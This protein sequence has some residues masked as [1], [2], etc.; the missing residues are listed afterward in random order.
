MKKNRTILC[1]AALVVCA[2]AQAAAGR[3]GAVEEVVRV[4]A[5]LVQ[6]GVS[7]F[8]KQGRFVDGLKKEDFELKVDGR[9]V[10]ITFFENIV[11]G[12]SRDRL[13]RAAATG[14]PTAAKAVASA[15]SFRQRT[16]VFF[17][18]DRHLSLDS[19]GRTRKMLLD[20]IEKEMGENDLVAFASASGRIGF[21][22]Q[23]TDDKAVLR[24]AV[25]RIDHVPYV[26]T[27][28]G[29]NPGGPMT[30]Y[31]ALTIERKDD[32][33]VFE[34]YVGDCLKWTLKPP[35][36]ASRGGARRQCEVEVQN[37]ARQ[38]LLQAGT[39]TANTYYSLEAL[40]R[41][42]EK[43]PGSKLAFF[44]SDGFLADTGPRSPVGRERLGRITDEARRAGVVIYTIDARG[45]VAGTLDAT[46]NVPMDANGQLDTANLREVVASQDALNALA[47]DT[48]GRALRNQNTFGR[49]V[50]DALEE[51]S[52][53]YLIAWRPEANE[54]KNEKLRKIEVSVEGRPELT[55]RSARGFVSGT[56]SAGSSTLKEEKGEE[57][58]ASKSEKK[59][60]ADLRHALTE[61]YPRQA[62]PL[63]LSLIYLDIPSSGTVLTTSV[64][65]FTEALSYGAQDREPAQLT[66]EGVVLDDQGKPAASFRTGLKVNPPSEADGARNA[67]NVIYNHPSPLK[68]GIYQVRVA[69]R[70]E[71][72]GVLGSAAQW[73]VIP[74]LSTR[75]LA[76]S[77]LIVGLEGVGDKGAEAGRIQWSVDKRFARGSRLRFMTFVY[78]AGAPG[79][80]AARVQ[81]Y[82]EGREVLGTPF[83]KVGTDAQTD[84]A[85]VPFTT[86]INL[87]A[88]QPGRYTLQ[89]TV[90]DR[91]AQRT[92]LQQTAFY[93]Q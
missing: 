46:G 4:N 54:G 90:E 24:A 67:S 37:R 76:L 49:F 59:P 73:V 30:E 83:Q 62:L 27:D 91:A 55:V 57:K 86:E 19:V 68:P 40:L 51:T 5:E 17:L 81:V 35:S 53:Y 44:I 79:N 85:R 13:A 71:R 63:Q 33:G 72:S 16:I 58:G 78:N 32:P 64:Q 26:V 21:L 89:V 22:Q 43:M 41:Y 10:P 66:L 18:D 93:V 29:G 47:A 6:T 1:A 60:D 52:R 36:A 7:V 70:D 34:F 20:F 82:R 92:A 48:G 84:P 45:L 74:D 23:F 50:N 15:P 61:F 42:A 88:L 39:V 2:F 87:G 80:L 28:Y 56:A 38:I 3:Q 25:A 31:M 8:D 14:E 75:Q 9:V 11:A 77:S 12:S 65:A 69:A